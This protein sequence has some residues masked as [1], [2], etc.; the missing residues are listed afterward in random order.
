MRS[1]LIQRWTRRGIATAVLA[2]ACAAAAAQG[3]ATTTTGT[4][5]LPPQVQ[6]RDGV[7][8][9]TGGTGEEN[10]ARTE[11]LGRPM[12]TQLVFSQTRGE[13]LANVR[14]EVADSAGRQV[15]ATDSE[16]MLFLNLPPG[17]Y[18]VAATANGERLDRTIDVP[19][20]GRHVEQFRWREPAK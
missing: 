15:L 3:T 16:A 13:Y 4:P 6:Q 12:N 2:T 19:R 14:V 11:E 8:W 10:R 5:P 1:D 9:V 18:R 7:T 20:S 17:R